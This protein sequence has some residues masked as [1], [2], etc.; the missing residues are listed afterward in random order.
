MPGRPSRERAPNEPASFARGIERLS[1][2][3][4]GRIDAPSLKPVNTI[5]RLQPDQ[6]FWIFSG[7]G[8][9]GGRLVAE[10]LV[11]AQSPCRRI[12]YWLDRRG[13]TG[14]IYDRTVYEEGRSCAGRPVAR[15]H[16]RHQFTIS[17]LA[18]VIAGF[19]VILA[20]IRTSVL[21]VFVMLSGFLYVMLRARPPRKSFVGWAACAGALAWAGGWCD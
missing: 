15:F 13:L 5:H 2:F 21:L 1:R 17:Q 16:R 20:M 14:T 6:E 12:E 8:G 10:G 4:V 9:I 3:C 11:L 18:A 7:G 19:A